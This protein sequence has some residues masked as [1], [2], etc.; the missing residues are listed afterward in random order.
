MHQPETTRIDQRAEF[1]KTAQP[2]PPANPSSDL[3]TASCQLLL[4]ESLPPN[5]TAT[6]IF[7]ESIKGIDIV[8]ERR[9]SDDTMRILA[10]KETLLE[11]TASQISKATYADSDLMMQ[12]LAKSG[13]TIGNLQA[14]ASVSD[15]SLSLAVELHP[16][17]FPRS[18]ADAGKLAL[19]WLGV[20]AQLPVSGFIEHRRYRAENNA[21]K[22]VQ[23]SPS[24]FEQNK[25]PVQLT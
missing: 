10:G 22:E 5:P 3:N 12:G 25:E 24:L 19:T 15:G 13:S 21:F 7:R 2:L 8:I 6:E 9:A 11:I 18:L 17:R 23:Y 20:L 16:L 14:R 4:A 1:P